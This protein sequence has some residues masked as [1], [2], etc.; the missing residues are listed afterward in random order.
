M[1]VER[2]DY[3]QDDFMVRLVSSIT[4]FDGDYCNIQI[5]NLNSEFNEAINFIMNGD[6]DS[7]ITEEITTL[8][9]GN[10]MER[11]QELATALHEKFQIGFRLDTFDNLLD[12]Y[13]LFVINRYKT[14]AD[15]ITSQ[16]EGVEIDLVDLDN[17]TTKLIET[18][19]NYQLKELMEDYYMTKLKK[20]HD[21]LEFETPS[22]LFIDSFQINIDELYNSEILFTELKNKLLS[23]ILKMSIK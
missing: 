1:T 23:Q 7:E 9:R 21:I 11:V 5:D 16:V 12:I 19:K 22:Q 20:F 2:L 14:I 8:Y 15:V 10:L 17:A 13:K 4:E 3:L 18:A 6:P